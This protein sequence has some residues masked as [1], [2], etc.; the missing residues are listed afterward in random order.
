[1]SYTVDI[2]NSI[3]NNADAEYKN[4]VPEATQ[5]NIADI[6]RVLDEYTP[7]YNTFINALLHKIGLTIIQTDLFTNKLAPF[8]SGKLLTGQD[9]EDIFVEAYR[10]AEG[11]YDKEGGVGEGGVHPFKRRSYQD[12]EVNYYRMNRQ[13]KYTITI[14]K[15][16]VIRAFRSEDKLA[17]FITAQFNSLY[18]GANYDEY[19]HMKQLF[20]EAIAGGMFKDYIVPEIKDDG[21]E[22]ATQKACK[23]F[24]RTVKKAIADVSYPSREYNP[25]K[26]M[27]HADKSQLALF[28]LKD[29]PPHLEVDLYSQV[30]GPSYAQLGVP[31]VELDNFGSDNSGTYALL[32]D[33][34][35]FKCYDVK[36]EMTSL[37][38]PDGLYTN[39]WL[40]IWQ[41]LAL[42]KY[43]TA[44]RLGTAAIPV[45]GA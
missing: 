10:E 3:R 2:L 26:V 9:V 5:A 43:K 20:V 41:I 28:I 31:I 6:G 33:K 39:Y 24:V 44:V 25:A 37:F 12:V 42:S 36:N 19:V 4:R 22:A 35:I 16:D 32:V 29:I 40:H 8:K 45:A 7:L 34:D 23:A 38:N 15:D 17:Q 11:S 13:D 14:Y 1:M 30:F 21:T 27:T 18:T